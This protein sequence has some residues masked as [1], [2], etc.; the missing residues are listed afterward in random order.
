MRY[1]DIRLNE[2]DYNAMLPMNHGERN[3]Y[4]EEN[5]LSMAI[6]YGYGFYGHSNLRI[7][8]GEYLVNITTGSS[9][10]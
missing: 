5:V 2:N 4:L 6:V 1:F 3:H 10:D 8:N 9:C 7:E